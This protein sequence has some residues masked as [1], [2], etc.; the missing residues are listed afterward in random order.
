MRVQNLKFFYWMRGHNATDF[1]CGFA[2]LLMSQLSNNC[3]TC[4]K[5]C[6]YIIFV[7]PKH[8]VKKA[9]IVI[10]MFI[11]ANDRRK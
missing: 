10:K 8:A 2:S 6:Q 1:L 11:D 7:C 5:V 4:F 3:P 9:S